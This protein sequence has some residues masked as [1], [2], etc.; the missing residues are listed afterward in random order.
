MTASR[1]LL[2]RGVMPP[3]TVGMEAGRRHS[4]KRF[5][6]GF[7]VSAKDEKVENINSVVIQVANSFHLGVEEDDLMRG[8]WNWNRNAW[9]KKR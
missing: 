1:T 2:G 8:C 6:H 4:R 3:R 9:P 5:F 7:K